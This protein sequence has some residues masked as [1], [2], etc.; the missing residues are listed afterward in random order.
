MAFILICKCFGAPTSLE[1]FSKFFNIKLIK[2]DLTWHIFQK[3]SGAGNLIAKLPQSIH[4][5]K[6]HCFFKKGYDPKDRR[7]G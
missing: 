2:D 4:G 7:I 6:R 3:E 1:L 5:W